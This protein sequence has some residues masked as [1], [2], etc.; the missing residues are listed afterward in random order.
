MD[1]QNA[2]RLYRYLCVSKMDVLDAKA[3][4]VLNANAR[5][6][7]KMDEKRK[8]IVEEDLSFDTLPRFKE[9]TTYQPMNTFLVKPKDARY[10]TYTHFGRDLDVTGARKAFTIE[11]YRELWLYNGELTRLL[12][13]AAAARD[14]RRECDRA[15]V[16]SSMCKKVAADSTIINPKSSRTSPS[17][18]LR[19]GP[20]QTSSPASNVGLVVRARRAN[21]SRS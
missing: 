7:F 9:F 19:V 5:V 8:R 1:R 13:D 21:V 18:T 4:T 11:E 3:L 14:G 16:A 10:V 15:D 17:W 2:V 12:L 20:S 6:E